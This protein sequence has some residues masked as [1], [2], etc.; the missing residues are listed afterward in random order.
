MNETKKP[1]SVMK[2]VLG[3]TLVVL[4]LNFVL[5]LVMKLEGV[6][7]TVGIAASVAVLVATWF[8]KST[9]RARTPQERSRFLWL[10]GG[11]VTLLFLALVLLA[12][13]KNTPNAAGLFIILLHYLSYPAFAQML[14]SEKSFSRLFPNQT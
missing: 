4:T 10:Y 3:A 5:R 13:I 9:G 2:F 1:V 6:P 7:V 8:A 12:S 14:M 11:I